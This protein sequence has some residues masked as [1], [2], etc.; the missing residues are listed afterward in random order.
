MP[1]LYKTVI[2]YS[3]AGILMQNTLFFQRLNDALTAEDLTLALS[4]D[5]QSTWP[6]MWCDDV[7]MVSYYAQRMDTI[8]AES[9]TRG[10]T[11]PVVGNAGPEGAPPTSAIVISLRTGFYGRS[12]RGRMY[13][14]G[15]PVNFLT[16][17]KLNA[18]ALANINARWGIFHDKYGVGGSNGN[19]EMGV[20]SRVVGGFTIPYDIV[21]YL[22]YTGYQLAAKTGTERGRYS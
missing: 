3:F 19:W 14:G 15:Y 12:A 5:C 6:Y 10:V 11:L 7:E 1:A 16:N 22:G 9:H 4:L 8:T 2:S 13:I 18:G 21:G 20:Y 17:G